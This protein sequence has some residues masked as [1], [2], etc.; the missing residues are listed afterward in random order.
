[1]TDDIFGS[2][3]DAWKVVAKEQP[4]SGPTNDQGLMITGLGGKEEMM[5][6][7]VVIAS[8]ASS[9]LNSGFKSK[10]QDSIYTHFSSQ[11]VE[12]E[13]VVVNPDHIEFTVLI[14]IDLS[15]EEVIMPL[16]GDLNQPKQQL[17]KHYLVVNTEIPSPTEI[18][19]YIKE[20]RRSLANKG[21]D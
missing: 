7:F 19:Q 9:K 12:L 21:I 2:M 13:K 10:V 5:R 3:P 14:H 20:A 4:T 8:T 1:M 18:K 6:Y 15:V 11:E 17:L 16:I